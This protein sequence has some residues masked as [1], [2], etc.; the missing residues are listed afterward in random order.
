MFDGDD[1]AVRAVIRVAIDRARSD[2]HPRVGSEHLLLALTEW[3]GP[4]RAVLARHGVTSPGVLASVR[5]AAP[6]GSG[7]AA[8]RRLL[9]ELGL[10]GDG[11]A[12]LASGADR[13]GPERPFPL[14]RRSARR[15]CAL[16]EPRLGLDAQAGYEASLRLA[17]GRKDRQHRP[18]H[19]LFALLDLDP[20]I[21]WV[22]DGMRVDVV[23]LFDELRAAFPLPRRGALARLDRRVTGARRASAIARRYQRT[24]GR[25]SPATRLSELI[26]G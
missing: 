19:L 7:F 2:G 10:V 12:V 4:V 20:G 3:P 21:A 9:A 24:T 13:P 1:E 11:L 16:L 25:T 26:A 18:E 22:L 23:P 14:A 8:D 15:R 17:L 6:T 5:S